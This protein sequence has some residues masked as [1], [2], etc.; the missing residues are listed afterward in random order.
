MV[1]H[2]GGVMHE[3]TRWR[4]CSKGTMNHLFFSWWH[5]HTLKQS[6]KTKKH[7]F[8]RRFFQLWIKESRGIYHGAANISGHKSKRSFLQIC[9]KRGNLSRKK[10][11]VPSDSFILGIRADKC[12]MDVIAWPSTYKYEL[13]GESGT[14]CLCG[15]SLSLHQVPR[16]VPGHVSVYTAAANH[17]KDLSLKVRL[18]AGWRQAIKLPGRLKRW[19]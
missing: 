19:N 9:C 12:A 13:A 10:T 7:V 15:N 14:E 11:R 8:F 6:F 1:P 3:G 4:E 16:S 5:V 2:P 18:L 17:T